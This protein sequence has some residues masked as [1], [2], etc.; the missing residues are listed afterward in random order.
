MTL[1]RLGEQ[2]GPGTSTFDLAIFPFALSA[3]SI[4][5]Q[6]FTGRRLDRAEFE[7]CN[8]TNTRFDRAHLNETTFAG[9]SLAG[10]SFRGATLRAARLSD[11]SVLY[12]M[13]RP[14]PERFVS[15]PNR[16]GHEGVEQ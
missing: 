2:G 12:G 1:L 9:C 13:A 3:V 6:D 15:S 7:H 8:L 11:G 5:D 10:S 16:Y 14:S 4:K